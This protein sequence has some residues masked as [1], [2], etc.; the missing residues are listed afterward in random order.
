MKYSIKSTSKALN[1]RRLKIYK[2]DYIKTFSFFKL[3][4]LL[5]TMM[6][7]YKGTFKNK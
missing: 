2:R 7:N 3:I 1:Y 5:V 4:S 6:V